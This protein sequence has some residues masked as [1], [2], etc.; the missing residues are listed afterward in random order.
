MCSETI[1]SNSYQQEDLPALARA[2]LP[3]VYQEVTRIPGPPGKVKNIVRRL[4]TPEP[5]KIERIIVEEQGADVI[6]LIYERPETPEQ[7]YTEK[8][9]IQ[10]S[11]QILS[12][13]FQDQ[14][15]NYQQE[16]PYI[17]S[18]P[19]YN[20]PQVYYQ[21]TYFEPTP[22]AYSYVYTTP[23]YYQYIYPTCQPV[24]CCPCKPVKTS[25][26]CFTRCCRCF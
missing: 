25:K 15:V 17:P 8:K 14:A 24:A 9:V 10:P 23:V 16:V 11:Q 7:V 18:T 22:L 12:Y 19:A 6:N 3:K 4:P 20:Y 26:C 13:T 2:R 1:V 5:D 21:D